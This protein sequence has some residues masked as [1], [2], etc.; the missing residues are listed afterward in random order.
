MKFLTKINR[1]Y[2]T[3]FFL[4]LSGVTVGGYFI[5]H[6]I[7]IR[8]AK[9][10][11]KAKEYLIE[12]QILRTGEIPN[13]HPV[14]EVK[15]AEDTMIQKPLFK[16]VEIRN[17]L[18]NEN[19]FFLEY[20]NK[21]K[22]NDSYYL[23]KLRQSAFENEDLVIVLALTLFVLLFGAF[24]I[25]FFITRKTNK[26][27]WSDFE[28]NLREIEN[29]SLSG[30]DDISLV[31]S[32]IDEFDSLNRVMADLTR[33]LK[34]DYLSLKEFSENASHEIQTP[35]SIILLNLEELLQHDLDEETFTKVATSVSAVKRLST[36]NQSLLLLTKIENRQFAADKTVSLK[37]L[38]NRKTE[39]FSTLFESKEL[40]VDVQVEQDFVVRMNEQ[41]AE[42]LINNLFS[43]SV[44]HNIKGGSIQVVINKEVFKL[45][46]TA[47]D[48]SLTDGNI[49]NRFTS[50]KSNSSGL[51]LAIV[52]KICDTHNLEIHY[53]KNELHCFVIN[54]KS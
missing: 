29:F 50:G 13:L 4:I 27:V 32:G 22:I 42:I 3:F 38:V 26:T 47:K 11:L 37:E 15:E 19:E 48:N 53:L 54:Q 35:L 41:L 30:R 34:T 6:V 7:I 14:I 10:N 31:K 49:F 51:G 28:H 25:S 2:L 45:C 39:E 52:K 8:G 12:Q 33:K 46:N 1:N 20:S 21:I 40:K 5:L 18:E 16:E 17:E 24:I 44:N 23:I 36:L 43:N 9:E